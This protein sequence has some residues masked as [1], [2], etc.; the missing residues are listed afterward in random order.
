MEFEH[1]EKV[2]ALRARVEGFMVEHADSDE[3]AR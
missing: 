2:R 1:S 3:V